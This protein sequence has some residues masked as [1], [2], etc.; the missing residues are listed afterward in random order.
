MW[1]KGE[2]VGLSCCGFSAKTTSNKFDG[3]KLI[4]ISSWEGDFSLGGK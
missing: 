3:F 2:G 4:I 1:S